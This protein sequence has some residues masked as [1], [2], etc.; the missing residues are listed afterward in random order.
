MRDLLAFCSLLFLT[1]ALWSQIPTPAWRHYSVEQGLPSSETYMALQ[2]SRGYMWLATDRGVARFDGNQFQVFTTLDGLCD[3]TVLFLFEDYKN[4]LWF[5]TNSLQLSFF[6]NGSIHPFKNNHLLKDLESRYTPMSMAVDT[7]DNIWLG[8]KRNREIKN[9]LKITPDGTMLYQDELFEDSLSAYFAIKQVA[10]GAYVCGV[11]NPNCDYQLQYVNTTGQHVFY[12]D[13]SSKYRLFNSSFDYANLFKISDDKVL[14]SF[15]NSVYLLEKGQV[16]PLFAHDALNTLGIFQDRYENIWLATFDRGLLVY[17]KGQYDR[18]RQYMTKEKIIT[19]IAEDSEGG[20]WLTSLDDGVYY[21]PAIDIQC[22]RSDDF[23]EGKRIYDIDGNEQSILL[24]FHQGDVLELRYEAG[25]AFKTKK[26]KQFRQNAN[27]FAS[28]LDTNHFILSGVE[29]IGTE[30]ILNYHPPRPLQRIDKFSGNRISHYVDDLFLV[31]NKWGIYYLADGEQSLHEIRRLANKKVFCSAAKNGEEIYAGLNNGLHIIADGQLHSPPHP[32]PLLNERVNGIEVFGDYLLLAT[33][34]QG[35]VIRSRDTLWQIKEEDGLAS[36]LCNSVAVDKTGVAW[37]STNKGLSRVEWKNGMKAPPDM[38]TYSWHNGLLSNEVDEVVFQDSLI[39][40]KSEEGLSI[41]NPYK[42]SADRSPPNIYI[43]RLRV[44]FQDTL[45]ADGYQFEY[46]Q[47]NIQVSFAGLSY[48]SGD[49]IRYKYR[50]L[51][52]DSAW[53]MTDQKTLEYPQLLPGAYTLD[54]LARDYKGRWSTKAAQLSFE[55]QQ[56][57]WKSWW[58]IGFCLLLLL[59]LVQVVVFSRLRASRNRTRLLQQSFRAE[60]KALQAQLNPHFMFNAL[61]SVQELILSG[62]YKLANHNLTAVARLIRK[63]L[64]GSRRQSISLADEVENLKLFLKLEKL[65]FGDQFEWSLQVDEQIDS[66]LT[67]IPPMLIQPF[68]ENAIWHGLQHKQEE[69]GAIRI[70]FEKASKGMSCTIEDDGVGR[71]KSTKF[72]G[73]YAHEP[74]GLKI[75]EER[76]DL[77][78][79]ESQTPFQ[80]DIEDIQNQ[81][82]EVLGTRVR[83]FFPQ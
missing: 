51:G 17:P 77:L 18:P 4:R 27:V 41:F 37:V 52:L 49:E 64:N 38:L 3:N 6:E 62:K 33:L 26:I 8:F 10:G 61:G 34:G 63:L 25:Q 50:L 59:A 83:I 48:K 68:V 74:L 24:G 45:V 72:R 65:R 56:P 82:E 71:E 23:F 60:Q 42:E 11:S 28:K 36:N 76:I 39:W 2:D 67:E 5:L 13:V 19:W 78:N 40:V 70:Q 12:N 35:L 73:E 55:I 44:N 29:E 69:G 79:R 46:G 75:I 43:D 47:N 20:I 1:S 81:E 66:E 21:M 80:I 32:E 30:S 53:H 15:L 9:L 54:V 31:V 57:F 16:T 22:I 7:L 58:F 14:L